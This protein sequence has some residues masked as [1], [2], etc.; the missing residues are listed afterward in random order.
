MDG[1]FF[2]P[3]GTNGW[4]EKNGEKAVFDQQ[5]IE[6][7]CMT[8]AAVS[9]YTNTNEVK[10]REIAVKAFNWFH[11][12]NVNG[13]SLFNSET[14]TCYDGITSKGL[15]ENQGAES[16]ISYYMAYLVLKENGI[17]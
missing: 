3:I 8:E 12:M 16:T 10:Y 14:S 7:S 5:P 15:N 11:G 1:E 9:L 2:M 17:I 4:Y 13:V 6:A